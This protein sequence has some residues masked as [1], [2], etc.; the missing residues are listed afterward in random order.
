MAVNIGCE[1][2]KHLWNTY[3][4]WL[5]TFH[6]SFPQHLWTSYPAWLKASQPS[7]E[8]TLGFW[9]ISLKYLSCMAVSFSTISGTTYR[10][11]P[12]AFQAFSS[13]SGTIILHGYE[14][15]NHLWNNLS[16]MAV[17]FATIS[18]TTYPAC[19]SAFKH[20]WDIQY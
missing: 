1:L 18:G 11:W 8:T 12:L 19:L 2:F 9:G 10:A 5:S 16:C 3:P 13:I 17:G 7:L 6:S 20:L 14:L 4:A 15:F